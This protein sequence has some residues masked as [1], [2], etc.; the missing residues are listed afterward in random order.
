MEPKDFDNTSDDG[1]PHL[2]LILVPLVTYMA[3]SYLTTRT[4]D[5]VREAGCQDEAFKL[6]D[7]LFI[8]SETDKDYF[9]ADLTTYLAILR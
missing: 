1:F 3:Y 4:L 9:D 6:Y 7:L 8:A 2:W 5:E